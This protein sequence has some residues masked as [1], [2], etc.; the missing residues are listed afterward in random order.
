MNVVDA[1]AC[2]GLERADSDAILTLEG[3][4]SHRELW[5]AVE[6]TAAFLLDA[7][8]K[9]GE[10]VTVVAENSFFALVSFFG[11]VRAG[12]VAVPLSTGLSEANWHSVIDQ[13]APRFAFL[14]AK[15]APT[16][17]P[18]LPHHSTVVCDAPVGGVPV[19]PVIFES[20]RSRRVGRDTWPSI[21]EATDL[22]VVL[23]TSGSTGR[24]RGVMLTHRNLLANSASIIEYLGLGPE[25]RAMLVLPYYYS[26]GAS[27]VLTHLR[28]GGSLVI[29][30]RFIFPDKVLVRMQETRC[31]GFAGV[32]S[33]YQALLR[34]SKLRSMH[35]PDLRWVQQAGGRLSPALVEELR[36][37]LPSA[38]VYVMYGATENT[39]RIA[40][41]PPERLA[42]KPGSVG[43]AIPGVT[44]RLLDESGKSVGPGEIGE[45]VVEGDSVSPGY[46]KAP[47][48]TAVT[49]RGGRL[50]T[51][52]LA[53]LDD[54]GFL[55]IVDR[56]GD[57]L[58]CGGTRTSSRAVEDVLAEYPD[59]VE[60]AVLGV[61]DDVL[62][63]AVAAFVVAK[64]G[65]EERMAEGLLAFAKDWL[66]V[67][68]VPRVI[69]VVANLPKS[70]SGKPLKRELRKYLAAEPEAASARS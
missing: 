47:E 44:I 13:T 35:F 42:D 53:R 62:G 43:V 49:F 39:A 31:T 32:P 29:D 25:D 55:S 21:E 26:F 17:L 18:A 68:L 69:R 66:A 3:H 30:H 65:S 9:K 57:F 11:I 41:L 52:D 23:F 64:P 7:G 16:F 1:L 38:R 70:S 37:A 56:L 20:V 61:P 4:H 60:V 48:E 6:A 67:S 40:Y 63:E 15:C 33:H 10:L 5:G 51:G 46:F 59:V 54:E 2:R 24:P 12:A 58:K 27:V 50:H 8:V 14:D 22:A 19:E 28:V 36:A 34:R 45:V